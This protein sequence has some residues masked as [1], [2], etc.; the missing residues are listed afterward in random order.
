[1]AKSSIPAIGV[2]TSHAD[3]LIETDPS[4]PSGRLLYLDGIECSYVDLADPTHIEFGYIRRLADVIDLI[5][6]AGAPIRVT[7]L[8]GGGFSL[9]AYVAATRPTSRQIVYEYDEGLVELARSQ[10]GLRTSPQLR[11]K[12]GDAR[13]RLAR[14]SADSADVIV[15]DA[16]VGRHIP[17]HL[18][19]VEFAQLVRTVLRPG[20]VYAMNVIDAPPLA[21]ARAEG[22]VLLE[23]FG[24]VV[25]CTD[26]DVLRGKESGNLVYL[27]SDDPFPFE[28][29]SR[30]AGRGQLPERVLERI[31]VTRFVGSAHALHDPAGGAA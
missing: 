17:E 8:G 19:T 20:G 9:P 28:E 29:I 10:L 5:A 27:A 23:V 13:A 11:V 30:R 15:G 25:L 18:A 24:H 6:P 31:G 3:A 16:F 7:H 14:R 21:F 2:R 26:A 12:I 4:R 22:A 1:M